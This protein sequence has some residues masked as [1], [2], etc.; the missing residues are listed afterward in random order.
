MKKNIKKQKTEIQDTNDFE[1]DWLYD[2]PSD[3]NK[4]Y[5]DEELN[6]LLKVLLTLTVILRLGKIQYAN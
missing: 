4:P 5:N 1:P 2:T 6:Y 3:N